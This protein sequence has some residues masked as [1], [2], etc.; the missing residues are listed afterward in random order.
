MSDGTG[1]D[2]HRD[3]T[4]S[5]HSQDSS[6]PGINDPEVVYTLYNSAEHIQVIFVMM[7]DDIDVF[8]VCNCDIVVVV[9][10]LTVAPKHKFLKG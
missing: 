3:V 6:T 2:I 8:N 7:W 9:I 4:H 5:H 1:R 10:C